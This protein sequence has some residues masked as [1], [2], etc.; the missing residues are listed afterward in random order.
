MKNPL[1]LETDD[2]FMAANPHSIT[3]MRK[4][5][6]S[7]LNVRAVFLRLRMAISARSAA[8]IVS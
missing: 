3:R 7:N 4:L 2:S 6:H 5:G 8:S 1:K